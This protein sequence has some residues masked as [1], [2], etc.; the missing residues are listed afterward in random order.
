MIF[1]DD[2]IIR[3][4]V[5]GNGKVHKA[6]LWVYVRGGPGPPLVVFDFS[7]DRSK[8]RPLDF[9]DGY[10]AYVH[11]DA[12]SVYNELFR[13]E[14]VIEAS[15]WVHT[16]RKFEEA[17]SSRPQ[18]ATEVLTRIA[19][20]CKIEA[21]CNEIAPE[22]RRNVREQRSR[23]I[24]D[25]IFKRIE[26][27]KAI[28]YALNQRQALY[29]YLDDGRLKLDNNTAENAIPPLA[30]DR[31]NWL[32]ASSER[33]SRATALFLGLIRS[34]HHKPSDHS[35]RGIASRSVEAH[36]E[37]RTRTYQSSGGNHLIPSVLLDYVKEQ[38]LQYP[39]H[40]PS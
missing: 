22:Q 18:K 15:C 1:T 3:L 21:E 30:L 35:P 16:H 28:D 12:Y 34:W 19:Q 38:K 5:K 6:R 32:F 13:L 36:A 11:G 33:G 25:G 7:R 40:A 17:A 20:L 27:L 37:G 9:L 31:K 29:R 14:W 24:L 10:R 26:E 39:H 8:K 4:R 23:P 2:S